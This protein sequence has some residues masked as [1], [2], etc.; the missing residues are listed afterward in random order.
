M[1][2]PHQLSLIRKIEAIQRDFTRRIQNQ[3]GTDY[4]DRLNNLGIFSL[5]RRRE[6]YII[7]YVFKILYG[8]V[9]N[10]GV[11]WYSLPRQGRLIQVPSISRRNTFGYGCKYNSFFC[12]SARLFN[13]LPAHLRNM[14]CTMNTVK[15]HLDNFLKK[16][17]DQPRLLNYSQYSAAI[18]NSVCNQVQ[19]MMPA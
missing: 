12:L 16:V 19:F 5:E 9:P 10:P 17:P 2:N 15:S 14:N 11:Y 6:R 18:N 3:S 4:W 1:W 13:C 8:L 7:L